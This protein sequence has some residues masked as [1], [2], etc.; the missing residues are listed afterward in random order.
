MISPKM[1]S[2]FV[3]LIKPTDSNPSL[4]HTNTLTWPELSCQYLLWLESWSSPFACWSHTTV[5]LNHTRVQNGEVHMGRCE[6][7]YCTRLWVLWVHDPT[8]IR[9][10]RWKICARLT[11]GSFV[12]IFR[13][14]SSDQSES[15]LGNMFQGTSGQRVMSMFLWGL[16]RCILVRFTNSLTDLDLS[17]RCGVKRNRKF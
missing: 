14:V 8:L 11:S 17:N 5:Q 15:S 9:S 6:C 1:I 13:H 4:L 16:C 12:G 2:D 7:G 10:N 3:Q